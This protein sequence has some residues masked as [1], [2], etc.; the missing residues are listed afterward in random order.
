M[1]G[2]F[3]YLTEFV[4]HSF[5]FR[6]VRKYCQSSST[7]ACSKKLIKNLNAMKKANSRF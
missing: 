4:D 3:F 7:K 6:G 5:D 2:A 1:G